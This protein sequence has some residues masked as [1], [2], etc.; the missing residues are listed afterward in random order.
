LSLKVRLSP[1]IRLGIDSF[2]GAPC[3]NLAR[4]QYASCLTDAALASGASCSLAALRCAECT[5]E[6]CAELPNPFTCLLCLA[7]CTHEAL[8]C[9]EGSVEGVDACASA[10]A[11]SCSTLTQL[12]RGPVDPNEKLVAAKRFIQPN[13]LLVYPIHFENIGNAEAQDVF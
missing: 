6:L 5:A 8:E 10:F 4:Q 9:K 11:K 12:T 1:S 13:Q 2:G 3:G 7:K